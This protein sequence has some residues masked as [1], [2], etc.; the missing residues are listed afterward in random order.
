MRGWS[1]ARESDK[2]VVEIRKDARGSS[3]ALWKSSGEKRVRFVSRFLAER[4]TGTSFCSDD[5][6]AV[7]GEDEW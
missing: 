5:T 3:A 4:K 7:D 1:A 2:I 6:G